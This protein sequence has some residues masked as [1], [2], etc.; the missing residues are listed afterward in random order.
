MT[1]AATCG[2][3]IRPTVPY[4]EAAQQIPLTGVAVRANVTATATLV[5][6]SQQ[7]RND[8]KTPIEAVY[9]FPL[10][11]GSAV[12]GFAVTIDLKPHCG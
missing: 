9:V 7:Y 6:V 12:S 10:E 3:L 5:R 4:R 8:E 11:E 1:E 2:L